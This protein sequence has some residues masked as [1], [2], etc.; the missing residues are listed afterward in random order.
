MAVLAIVVFDPDSLMNVMREERLAK[1]VG[2]DGGEFVVE[3]D[4][5]DDN[6]DSTQPEQQT[7]A[8]NEAEQPERPTT[9]A[10][11]DSVNEQTQNAQTPDNADG[12]GT[13]KK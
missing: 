3:D 12:Q 5:E 11:D 1:L 4:V 10:E 2:E 9:N 7:T 6:T 13:D 8:N